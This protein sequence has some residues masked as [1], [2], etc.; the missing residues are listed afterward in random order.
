MDLDLIFL[1]MVSCDQIDNS[2]Y[3]VPVPEIHSWNLIN[4]RYSKSSPAHLGFRS[5]TF[6]LCALKR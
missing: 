6:G 5:M 3:S 4:I 2:A 1:L